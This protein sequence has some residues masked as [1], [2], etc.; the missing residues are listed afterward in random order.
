MTSELHLNKLLQMIFI[1]TV[2]VESLLNQLCNY[3]FCKQPVYKQLALGWQIAKQLSW[4]RTQP[5]L[6]KQR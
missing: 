4:L 5:S 6:T 3:T 2:D 1:C